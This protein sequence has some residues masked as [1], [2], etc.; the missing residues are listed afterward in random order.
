MSSQMDV[1]NRYGKTIRKILL[2]AGLRPVV[3]PSVFYRLLPF[4]HVAAELW[5]I[6]AVFNF[7]RLHAK[8]FE[9]VIKGLGL[10]LTFLISVLKM[11]CLTVHRDRLLD[12][13]DNLEGTF[14][15]DLED[16]ELRPILLSPLLTYYRPSLVFSLI[17]YTLCILYSIIPI[18]V[19]IIQLAHGVG[20]VKYILPFTTVYPWSI[21]PKN[22]WFFMIL[23]VFETYVSVCITSTAASVD[24]LFGYYIFQISGEL[25]T[26]AHRLRNLKANGHYDKV[27]RECVSRHEIL[28]RCQNHLEHIY[29]PI[30]L[31]LS[32]SNA[33]IICAMIWQATHVDPKKASPF[34]LFIV[35]KGVQT[36]FYGWFGSTLTT[37]NE[38]FSEA[39]YEIDWPGSG[40]KSLMTSV[41]T[42]ISCNKP[43]VLSACSVG[44]ITVDM[45][46]A[47]C[48][49]ALSYYCMLRTLEEHKL[50]K[51][52]EN[53]G[54][55]NLALEPSR[56][57]IRKSNDETSMLVDK[58]TMYESA[59]KKMLTFAGVWPRT[60]SSVI[61]RVLMGAHALASVLMIFAI[62]KFCLEH[63]Q[64]LHLFLTGLSLGL[65]FVTIIQKMICLTF[66]RGDLFELHVTL[67][68]TFAKDY[69][70]VDLRP[71]LMSPFLTFYRP[72]QVMM[73]IAWS[74][75]A[76]YWSVPL[77]FILIQIAKGANVIK[78]MLPFPTSFP[79][80]ISANKL[81]YAGIY[82]FEIY[83][84]T[85]LSVF[86]V[87]VDSLFGYYIFQISGQLRTLSHRIRNLSSRD[88]HRQVITECVSR[89]QTLTRCQE[90][91]ER[92]YGPIVLW[93]SV[94]SA[95]VLCAL[96]YQ[97]AHLDPRKAVIVVMYIF[98]KGVQ[99][100]FYGWSGTALS[101][102]NDNFREAIYA[103]DWAG[104]GEKTLMTNILILLIYNKPFVLKACSVATISVDMFIAVSNTAISYYFMLRTLE[105][106][107]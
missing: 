72:Y 55:S 102:E 83:A 7:T 79:W 10:A 25:R 8:D 91:L 59:L 75:M 89:H 40:E 11:I 45:F 64:N 16:P 51:H 74:G 84:S 20:L 103:S 34:V 37:E 53:L 100:L 85:C 65:G 43:F 68:H 12:L 56:V 52:R 29:G 98:I 86:T 81:V 42:M 95:M 90:S 38:K 78:Y 33:L 18:V 44:T 92:I 1:Y 26:L 4:V 82:I 73:G 104:S 93:L 17:L 6:F 23:Y 66:Y 35:M 39:I 107:Q 15:Q 69:N 36:L 99:T 60:R 94:A 88:N 49:T 48:N 24:A 61:D 9:L 47:V 3:N 14:S 58:Y 32:I 101:T 70:N 77:V 27:I 67:A 54:L 31:C 57:K 63:I 71:I 50:R 87:A 46:I 76:L 13:R 30:V 105:E 5:M 62:T 106:A 41:L 2:L 28:T 22:K 96:I 80:P 19:I 21:G 97:A